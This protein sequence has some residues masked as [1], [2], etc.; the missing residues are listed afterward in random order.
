MKQRFIIYIISV[1]AAL[2]AVFWYMKSALP[3][4][5]FKVLMG[6]NALM[7]VLSLISFFL[8]TREF[9][10]KPHAFVRGVYAGTFLKLLSCMAAIMIYVMLNKN[11]IHKPT[12]FVLF[13]IYAVYSIVETSLLSKIARMK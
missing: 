11:D 4:Y 2:T 8:V 6:A 7:L 13:G 3:D 9:K 1:F 5:R 12:L 10:N